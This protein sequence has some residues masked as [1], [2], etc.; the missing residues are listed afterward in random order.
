MRDIREEQRKQWAD[1][2]TFMLWQLLLKTVFISKKLKCKCDF[3][4]TK[5]RGKVGKKKVLQVSQLLKVKK[6][7]NDS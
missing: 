6:Y 7:Y 1:V 2:C 3:V 5:A 4:F